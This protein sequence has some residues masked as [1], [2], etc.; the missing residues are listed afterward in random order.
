MMLSSVAT[1]HRIDLLEARGLIERLP[2]PADRRGTRVRLT[3]AGREL[4]DAVVSTHLE[5]EVNL[6]SGLSTSE[7]EELSRLLATWTRAMGL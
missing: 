7:R 2:D 5:T 6:L 4:V 1:T 3:G